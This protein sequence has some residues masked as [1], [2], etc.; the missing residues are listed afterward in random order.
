M[1]FSYIFE[2]GPELCLPSL[3][4]SVAQYVLQVSHFPSLLSLLHYFLKFLLFLLSQNFDDFLQVQNVK[5]RCPLLDRWL[6]KR[7]K[8]NMKNDI[9]YSNQNNHLGQ[10]WLQW[11]RY[12]WAQILDLWLLSKTPH[13]F[14]IFSRLSFNFIKLKQCY[15][16]CLSSCN[17]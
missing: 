11:I 13:L 8:E 14:S 10:I 16:I 4:L 9:K 12:G 3:F 5:G 7:R 17:I 2:H 15:T 6:Y 1:Y